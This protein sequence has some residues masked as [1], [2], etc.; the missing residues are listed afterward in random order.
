MKEKSVTE[1]VCCAIFY[2]F[3]CSSV[4]CEILFFHSKFCFLRLLTLSLFLYFLSLSPSHDFGFFLC[5]P[6]FLHFIAY[7]FSCLFYLAHF[8]VSYF[9][10]LSLFSRLLIN[11]FSFCPFLIQFFV[12]YLFSFDGFLIF[13]MIFVALHSFCSFL[14]HQFR[15]SFCFSLFFFAFRARWLFPDSCFFSV[16][17]LCFQTSVLF[18]GFFVFLILF[19]L[20]LVIYFRCYRSI[21]LSLSLYLYTSFYLF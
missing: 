21:F 3:C 1:N 18:F 8:P 6:I 16:F 20:R 5:C 19:A 9:I 4:F 17:I 10:S 13:L 14:S 15:I 12:S 7:V 2:F 11:F